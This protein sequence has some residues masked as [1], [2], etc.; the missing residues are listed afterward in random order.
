MSGLNFVV[1]FGI[2]NIA[3]ILFDSVFAVFTVR[4]IL[5]FCLFVISII[6]IYEWTDRHNLNWD[7]LSVDVSD[8][9]LSVL[10][11]AAVTLMDRWS[12]CPAAIAY[13][14]YFI[15]KVD[16]RFIAAIVHI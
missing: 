5:F 16:I 8:K 10:N 6:Q 12:F 11:D 2:L 15:Y 7:R 3:H 9:P 4:S 13:S 1:M 14:F